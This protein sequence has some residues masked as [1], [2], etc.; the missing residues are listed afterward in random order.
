VYSELGYGNGHVATVTF[1]A[2]AGIQYIGAQKHWK[3]RA[4]FFCAGDVRTYEESDWRT[5][6]TV[7]TGFLIPVGGRSAVHR[8]AVEAGHGRTVMGQFNE[9]DE[10][11]LG[12]GWFYDF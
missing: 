3:N 2:Q 12:I 10:T 6:T 7:Q 5:R 9:L 4:S 8:F 1:R 11:W